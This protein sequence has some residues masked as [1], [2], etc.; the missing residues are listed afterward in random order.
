MGKYPEA[1]KWAGVAA[2][3]VIIDEFAEYVK[4]TGRLFAIYV[5]EFNFPIVDPTSLETLFA[6][7]KNIDLVKL[8]HERRMM[9][10][11]INP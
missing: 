11:E 5:D 9:L 10:K 3:L 8:E 1:D 6:Q 2:D 7:W 4:S